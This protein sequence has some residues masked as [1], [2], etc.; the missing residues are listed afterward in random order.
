MSTEAAVRLLE[1]P[2]IEVVDA[3]HHHLISLTDP[4]YPLDPA[5]EPGPEGSAE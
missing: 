4:E 5:P 1:E 3:H 2:L